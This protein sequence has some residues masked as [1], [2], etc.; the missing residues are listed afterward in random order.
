MP[1][2]LPVTDGQPVLTLL[3]GWVQSG[4]SWRQLWLRQ[5]TVGGRLDEVEIEVYVLEL[6]APDAYR[7]DLIA[8]AL[9]EH[10]LAHDQHPVVGYYTDFTSA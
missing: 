3:Q 8:Q 2:R 1:K 10:F 6:L 9:N 5:L 7:H 4:M